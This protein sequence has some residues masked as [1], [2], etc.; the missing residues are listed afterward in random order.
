MYQY[1]IYSYTKIETLT[2]NIQYINIQ[3]TVPIQFSK[4][5]NSQIPIIPP[6]FFFIKH[7]P[8]PSDP[9][10]PLKDFPNPEGR[11]CRE[12][13]RCPLRLLQAD[14]GATFSLGAPVKADDGKIP[15][16]TFDLRKL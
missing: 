4:N 7:L 14:M 6:P 11:L 13:G 5:N 10:Q 8:I 3:E 2:F 9:N 12:R 15:K 16:L 1:N